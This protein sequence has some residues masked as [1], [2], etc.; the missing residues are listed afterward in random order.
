MTPRLWG[1]IRQSCILCCGVPRTYR[2][3]HHLEPEGVAD[4]VV[5]Q[6]DGALQ[7]R[8]GP[9]VPV[10]VGDVQ[11][12]DG[13]GVDLVGRLGHGALHRLLVLVGENRRHCGVLRDLER[14]VGRGLG[15]LECSAVGLGRGWWGVLLTPLLGSTW[16]ESQSLGKPVE[17]ACG[18]RGEC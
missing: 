18:W 15:V 13:D 11:L 5:C 2:Y 10:G 4:Q 9:S 16:E 8:V 7:A 17:A 14:G 3:V 6:H 12:G 1:C